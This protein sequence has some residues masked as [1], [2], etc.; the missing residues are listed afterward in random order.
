MNSPL[1]EQKKEK[2]RNLLQEEKNEENKMEKSFIKNT[3]DIV[4]KNIISNNISEI[5][6]NF[7]N[8][9]IK[10][11]EKISLKIIHNIKRR[12]L[13]D[14][15]QYNFKCKWKSININNNSKIFNIGDYSYGEGIFNIKKKIE[16]VTGQEYLVL[17]MKN[18]E[19]TYIDNWIIHSSIANLNKIDININNYI[20]EIKGKFL[21]RLYRGEY[22]NLKNV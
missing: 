11:K 21:T 13:N 10:E 20:F 7:T 17:N 5:I 3:K 2:L 15:D 19:N 6:N 9:S 22:F 16:V 8:S 12:L 14:L 4:A 18:N 1:D